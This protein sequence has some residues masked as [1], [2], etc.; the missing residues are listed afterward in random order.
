[1]VTYGEHLARIQPKFVA[2]GFMTC[3]CMSLL[4]QAIGGAIADT[5]DYESAL[6]QTGI[7]IMI[8]GL[9][10]QVVGLATFLFVCADFAWRCKHGKLDM[11]REKVETRKS[12]LL[13]TTIG[14]LVLATV[15]VL[16]RSVFRVDELWQGFNG[17]LWN[18]EL[19]FILLDGMMVAIA[20]ICLTM[21]H[22]GPG[23]GGQWHAAN[24]TFRAKKG[25]TSEVSCTVTEEKGGQSS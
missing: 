17:A 6:Q 2:L 15:C 21:L 7:N 19:E 11:A 1:M 12:I 24:W 5:A 10:L 9:I 22:P 4:L 16:V 25:T 20:S 18:D 23:F 8:G 3:D 13:K 14:G